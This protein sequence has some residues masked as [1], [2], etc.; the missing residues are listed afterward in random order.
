[1]PASTPE[2]I[3]ATP[4]ARV[5]LAIPAAGADPEVE[6]QGRADV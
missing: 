1:M 5:W 6:K 3:T 2:A 4:K